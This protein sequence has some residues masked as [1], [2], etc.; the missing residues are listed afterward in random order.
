[1]SSY[2]GVSSTFR[3]VPKSFSDKEFIDY[4]VKYEVKTVIDGHDSAALGKK[5]N[6]A[7]NPK[8]NLI[9]WRCNWWHCRW[10]AA[11]PSLNFIPLPSA[12]CRIHCATID[13]Q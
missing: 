10:N 5:F 9:S 7:F 4:N 8:I 3:I 2:T 13:A 11:R 6:L 12:H 1:M